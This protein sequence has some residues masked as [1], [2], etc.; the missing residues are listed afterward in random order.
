MKDCETIRVELPGY[1]NGKLTDHFVAPVRDHLQSC[2]A[3]RAELGELERLAALLLEALPPITPSASFASR[4]ANRLAAEAR[5][6]ESH[7]DGRGW[8]GWLLQPWLIPVAAAALLAAVMLQPWFADHSASVFPVGGSPNTVA[9]AKK[10]A[11]DAK[12]AERSTSQVT[13]AANNPPS[14]VLQ[15]P[16]LFVDYSVIRDLDILESGKGDGES[17]AG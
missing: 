17:H 8:L 5:D 12:L 9:A 10:P 11:S 1:A 3:C 2:A 14:E 13:L 4:F 15:R 7:S 16:E 6:P